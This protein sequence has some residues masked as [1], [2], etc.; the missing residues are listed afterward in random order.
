MNIEVIIYG[1][2]FILILIILILITVLLSGESQFITRFYKYKIKYDIN[3]DKYYSML[4]K[5]KR[6]ILKKRLEL[7]HLKFLLKIKKGI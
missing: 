1:I 5:Q 4:K 6:V 7:L 2:F 3:L